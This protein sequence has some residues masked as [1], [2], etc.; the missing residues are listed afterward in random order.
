[1]PRWGLAWGSARQWWPRRTITAPRTANG[2]TTPTPP[3]AVRLM[4]ITGRTGSWAASSS[5]PAPGTTGAGTDI[6]AGDIAAATATVADTA[7]GA[8]TVVD[9]PTDITMDT[10]GAI[11]TGMR[12]ATA[13]VTQVAAHMGSLA[14][15]P[16]LTE[17][18]AAG[19][20]VGPARAE[21]SMAAVAAAEASMVAVAAVASTAAVEADTGNSRLIADD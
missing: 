11:T 1:M 21:A 18:S 8:G 13:T 17:T 3:T 10:R 20:V 19:F 5:A 7:I 12:A 16:L 9:T 15:R 4:A 6:R 2:A 14:A